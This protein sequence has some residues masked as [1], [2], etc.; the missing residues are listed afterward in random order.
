MTY[1][2]PKP[3]YEDERYEAWRTS[4]EGMA[5]LTAELVAHL[6]QH[7]PDSVAQ[8]NFLA[9]DPGPVGC[10]YC[11]DELDIRAQDIEGVSCYDNWCL[12]S[13]LDHMKNPD[14]DRSFA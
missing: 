13:W 7:E 11:Q 2:K 9:Q 3:D 5:Y 10:S 4:E 12:V 1:Q 14:E 6:Y 8:K